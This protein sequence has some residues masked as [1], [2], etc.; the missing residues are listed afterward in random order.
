MEAKTQ[1]TFNRY[2]R[3]GTVLKNYS[4]VLVLLL[5]LRQICSHPN[6]IQED[7]DGFVHPDEVDDDKPE[8]RTELTRARY[9]VSMEF[10][11]GLKAKFKE[12]A[13]KRIAAEKEVSSHT[14]IVRILC[15]IS[16]SP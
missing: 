2:L 11:D 15:L 5:R 13:L 16:P 9:L 6:L 3:A 4:Q 8:V 7:G 1:A 10:V 14:F 12:A